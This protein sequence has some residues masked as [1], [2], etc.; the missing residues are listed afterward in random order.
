MT[1]DLPIYF[2]MRPLDEDQCQF[3]STGLTLKEGKQVVDATPGIL[4]VE[5]VKGSSAFAKDSVVRVRPIHNPHN[6]RLN[7]EKTP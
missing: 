2:L 1:E 5:V 4:L 7:T 3:S 6:L